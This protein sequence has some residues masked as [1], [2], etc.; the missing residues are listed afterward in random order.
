MI[1]I[2]LLAVTNSC[3]AL[4]AW[5]GIGRERRRAEPLT[6]FAATVFRRL[7]QLEDGETLAL[8]LRR[9]PGGQYKAILFYPPTGDGPN[10]MEDPLTGDIPPPP[11]DLPTRTN[12]GEAHN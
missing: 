6:T 10:F 11:R 2:I 5:L 9:M 1:Y 8:T 7:W 3:V 4:G 12:D